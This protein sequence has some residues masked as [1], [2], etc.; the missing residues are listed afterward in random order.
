MVPRAGWPAASARGG[1]RAPARCVGGLQPEHAGRARFEDGLEAQGGRRGSLPVRIAHDHQITGADVVSPILRVPPRRWKL[2]N[3]D[4]VAVEPAESPVLSGG[5]S[6]IHKIDGI[7]AGFVV[8]LWHDEVADEIEQVSTEEAANMALRLARE[9]GLFAG[10]S[11]GG[12][13]VAALRCAERLGPDATVVT[14]MCDTGMKYLSTTM[15]RDR[16]V[17]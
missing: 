5:A 9:E 7:G 1:S 3:I 6:G 2:L 12:N 15:F 4:I 10:T 13:V 11:T 14:V 17:V 16:S 8:P